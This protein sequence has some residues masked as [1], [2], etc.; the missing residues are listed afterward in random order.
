MAVAKNKISRIVTVVTVFG[1]CI[2]VQKSDRSFGL[3][4]NLTGI[5]AM[6]ISTIHQFFLVVTGL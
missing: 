3:I 4:L 5:K 6:I 1:Y 2:S